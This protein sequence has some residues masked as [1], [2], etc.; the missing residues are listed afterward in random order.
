MSHTTNL[1]AL[2]IEPKRF[3]WGEVVT[4]HDIG[5]YSLVE[6]NSSDH[7]A[8]EGAHRYSVYVDGEAIGHGYGSLD[9][10]LIAA[11]A[12]GNGHGASEAACAWKMLR[13]E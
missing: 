12:W 1:A 11:I 2:R 4:I 10:A 5:R 7:R 6:F 13:K 3:T 8:N 9:Q